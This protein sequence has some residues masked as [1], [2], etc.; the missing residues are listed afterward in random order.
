MK[1]LIEHKGRHLFKGITL[2]EEVEEPYWMEKHREVIEMANELKS[3]QEIGEEVGY[4]PQ[5]VGE[6][7]RKYKR[8]LYEAPRNS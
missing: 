6:L 4:I 2:Y 1:I 7:I 3:T 5:Y 8:L